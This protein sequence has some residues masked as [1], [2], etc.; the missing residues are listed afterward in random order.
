MGA[1]TSREESRIQKDLAAL[2]LCFKE[3]VDDPLDFDDEKSVTAHSVINT[4]QNALYHLRSSKKPRCRAVAMM[5]SYKS[6]R[7]SARQILCARRV[8]ISSDPPLEIPRQ[9]GGEMLDLCTGDE[10]CMSSR[11]ERASCN[12]D[13]RCGARE[14]L[15]LDAWWPSGGDHDVRSSKGWC[16]HLLAKTSPSPTSASSSAEWPTQEKHVCVVQAEDDSAFDIC[17]ILTTGGVAIEA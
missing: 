17:A 9:R 3:S 16:Q 7:K 10:I 6:A 15:D 2:R 12:D 8:T 5:F 13:T 11:P 4:L 14:C 1:A